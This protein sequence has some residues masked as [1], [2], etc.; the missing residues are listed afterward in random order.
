MLLMTQ[1]SQGAVAISI[2]NE[3]FLCSKLGLAKAGYLTVSAH[4]MNTDKDFELTFKIPQKLMEALSR[5][6]Q[7]AKQGMLFLIEANTK[8]KQVDWQ[9]TST[10][11]LEK[12]RT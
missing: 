3:M 1:K 10:E 8:T 6:T 11:V 9:E 5:F 2:D 12:F 7:T 4:K